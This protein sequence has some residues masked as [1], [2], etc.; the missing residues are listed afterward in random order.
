MC[1][2]VVLFVEQFAYRVY[3]FISVFVWVVLWDISLFSC[4]YR[5]CCVRVCVCEHSLNFNFN[6]FYV[7]FPSALTNRRVFTHY[8][9]YASYYFVYYAVAN[10]ESLCLSLAWPI[11][12]EEI[13][14]S[15]ETTMC[16][17]LCVNWQ[18]L[19]VMGKENWRRSVLFCFF[20]LHYFTSSIS[21]NCLEAVSGR[22]VVV[23][24]SKIT[25]FSAIKCSSLIIC[26]LTSFFF[27]HSS[28]LTILQPWNEIFIF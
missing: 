11:W 18:G 16:F 14:R 5:S 7:H 9:Y 3:L 6:Q 27:V 23:H 25:V 22:L 12:K 2:N 10:L 8:L 28:H 21:G 19:W 13:I 4:F 17:D 20:L 26:P 15:M 24:R 1:D